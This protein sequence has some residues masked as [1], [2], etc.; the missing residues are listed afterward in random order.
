LNPQLLFVLGLLGLCVALFV[1][2]RPR[3]DV[4]ALLALLALPLAGAVTV[5]EALAGFSDP[6]V[7]L[8]ALLFVVGEGLV[9]TGIANRIGDFLLRRAG[10]SEARLISLLM[11]SVAVLGSIMSSTGVVAIFIPV[12]LDI[13]ERRQLPPGRLMMPLSVAGLISGML[14]LIGTAPNLV[15]NSALQEAGVAGFT[16]FSF[17]PFGAAILAA[18]VGYMLMARRRLSPVDDGNRQRSR[19]RNLMDFVR[20]YRLAAREH[21]LR[22]GGN[23]PLVGRTLEQL[24]VEERAARP[25]RRLLRRLKQDLEVDP[26]VGHRSTPE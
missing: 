19:R 6:N 2:N 21:R 18:G 7:V 12:V 11:V 8:I 5:P 23:S 3:M 10:G 26:V 14:T 1:A 17:T 25:D 9:R 15:A 16:F 20:D 22:V 13:A 24:A 4:V